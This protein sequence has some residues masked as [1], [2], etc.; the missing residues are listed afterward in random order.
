MEG[1]VEPQHSR[2]M[3]M[4]WKRL[5]PLAVPATIRLLIVLAVGAVLTYVLLVS[6]PTRIFRWVP[7]R[8]GKEVVTQAPDWAQHFVAYL[9]FSFLLMWYGAAKARWVVPCLIGFAGLHAVATEFLQQFVPQRTSDVK[10]LVV[11]FVG[12][13]MGTLLCRV[14]MKLFGGERGFEDCVP[15]GGRMSSG[16]AEANEP[17]G[18]ARWGGRRGQLGMSRNAVA[19]APGELK[20]ARVLNFGFLGGLC[21]VSV[22]LLG[23]LHV[24]HGWQVQQHA[25]SLME[26]G[27]KAQDGGDLKAAKDYFGRYVGLVPSDMQA[28]ADYGLLLDQA[29][30]SK[31][32]VFMVFEDVLRAEPTREEIRRRQIEIAMETGRHPDALVHVKFLRQSYPTDG[33]LDFQA[34][35]C[36]EELAEYADALKAYDAALEHDPDLLDT[37]ERMAR[38]CQTRLDRSERAKK[39]LDTM[40]ERFSKSPRSW[41][42][43][44]RFRA[45]FGSLAE[46]QSDIDRA[47]KLDPNG[48]ETQLASAR[49]AFDRATAA[50][51]NGRA[52]LAQQIAAESRQQLQ[53]VVEQHSDHVELRLQLAKLEAQFGSPTEAQNQ[54]D[55]LLKLSP[56][57]GRARLLLAEMQLEQG[58]FDEA[59]KSLDKLPRTPGSDALRLFLRGRMLM[60]QAEWSAAVVKLEEARRISTQAS[61]LIERTDLALAQCHAALDKV[62]AETAAFR[63]VLKSNPVSIPARL[64][65][66]ACLQRQ[67]KMNEAIAEFR[68]L[69]H[70]PQVRL[71]L[72]R[73][74][75]ARNLQLP[76]LAREWAEVERLL[77]QAKQE[78]SDPVHETLL[79]AELLAARGQTE[80]A[81]QLIEDARATQPDQV[82]FWW[83]LAKLAER[84]GD[85]KQANLWKGQALSAT[86]DATQ[87]EVLLRKSLADNSTGF[88]AAL[89][90]LR[91]LVRH[92]QL[93]EA[94]SLFQQ[95][96]QRRQLRDRPLDWAACAIA[97]GDDE[98]AQSELQTLLKTSPSDFVAVRTLAELHLRHQRW[99]DASP[100]LTRLIDAEAT[101]PSSDVRWARRQLAVSMAGAGDSVAR[102]RALTLLDRNEKDVARSADDARARAF[103]LASSSRR[104]DQQEAVKLLS[105]L[106]DRQQLP[107][108]DRWLLA[109]SFE[110]LGQFEE[111]DSQFRQ[112]LADAPDRADYLAEFTESLIRRGKLD[113]AEKRLAELRK[114]A[115]SASSFLVLACET[116]L[117]AARGDVAAALKRIESAAN[118]V[119]DAEQLA[120]LAA[121]AES[122]LNASR[123]EAA[124]LV[125]KLYRNAASKQPRFVTDLVRCLSQSNKPDEAFEV[126]LAEWSRLPIETTA[127]L[128]LS[129]LKFPEGR[130]KR[131]QQLEAK[132]LKAVE[133]QPR[134]A[135][136]QTNLADL[137]CWQERYADA[138]ELYRR[139]LGLD[140]EH[141]AAANNLARLL[142]LRQHDLDD[143]QSLIE[144]LIERRGPQPNLLDT[145]GCVLLSLRR[146]AAALQAFTQAHDEAPSA[147]SRFHIAVA[148]LET[149]DSAAARMSLEQALKLGLKIDA[150]HPLERPWATKL[151]AS[152]PKP[153]SVEAASRSLK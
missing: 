80:S 76:E 26:L 93:D 82:E 28:R 60:S 153:R 7:F 51:A 75:I 52:A 121:L 57:E 92:D 72:V 11:N 103:V 136:L 18:Q 19:I 8:A 123:I 86:G 138:E 40:V 148:Q 66:A 132:L 118:S 22:T 119:N 54:I 70:L 95:L 12:I 29:G 133:Q 117:L 62:D 14:A 140:R 144:R 107:L 9:C 34:G 126:C 120:R 150:L 84:S 127:P 152:L 87:A 41:L 124:S 46:A 10:D 3:N 108:K 23:T 146:T 111:A 99:N 67:Q 88:D 58:R 64:G 20:P 13:G 110:S 89:A 27:R 96:E 39:L 134:S 4:N 2:V 31:R 55:E 42:T 141:A 116:R 101:I 100:L 25:G 71:Q 69:A 35:R 6:D 106:A 105:E 114:M 147:T 36:S 74:L 73:L 1:C 48:I 33:K 77:D 32:Q 142:A 139:A 83:A 85:T 151:E 15:V 5:S 59:Q 43:R 44:G 97:L 38:L 90:L 65:L 112:A 115:N 78:Q 16:R 137:R 104:A 149:G 122:V 113:E 94:K 131:M 128:A 53:Q 49:L 24:V 109:R 98:G 145:R 47:V 143:A 130:E 81:R 17:P 68:P 30:A 63:R 45:E 125:E 135:A 61:G 129:L 91:H 79:R 21:V 50:R 37:Y 56:R 102:L